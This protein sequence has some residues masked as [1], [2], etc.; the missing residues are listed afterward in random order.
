MT[1]K[2]ETMEP[3]SKRKR[4]QSKKPD[5]EIESRP[6]QKSYERALAVLTKQIFFR[7]VA[8][9]IKLPTERQ[10]ASDLGVDRTSLRVALKQLE[11]MKVLDIRQGGGIYV[12]DFQKYAGLEFISSLFEIL[13][14]EC[15]LDLIDEYLIDEIWE[16]WIEFMPDII[17]LAVPRQTTRDLKNLID[18]LD[19]ELECIGDRDKIVE[20][21]V[22]SQDMVAEVAKNLFILL[23]MNTS[24]SLRRRMLSLL[25]HVMDEDTIRAHILFK[26]ELIFE[27]IR[28]GDLSPAPELYRQ[29]LRALRSQVRNSLF[30]LIDKSSSVL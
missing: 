18:L 30:P 8:P 14:A 1:R 25:F 7:Q 15:R 16:F 5:S 28:T 29:V 24:R 17:K 3:V 4:I 10:L 26:K 21:E 2:K 6:R 23:L 11:S 13:E 20:L 12:R 19:K 27:A 22:E 9:G